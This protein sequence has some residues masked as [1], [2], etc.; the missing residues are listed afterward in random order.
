MMPT[1]MFSMYDACHLACW[2]P[3]V[4]LRLM[5]AFLFLKLFWPQ[6]EPPACGLFKHFTQKDKL[7]PRGGTRG[8]GTCSPVI[9][10]PPGPTSGCRKLH[11]SAVNGYQDLSDWNKVMD[12][13]QPTVLYV[14][15][16]HL[17]LML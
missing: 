6:I 15:I 3:N 13:L 7:G 14:Y 5:S 17:F 8:E 16:M 1:V 11:G 2:H 12:E 4:Q 10:I 9:R